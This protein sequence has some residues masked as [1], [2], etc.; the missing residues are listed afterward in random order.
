MR[1]GLKVFLI[2]F[3]L[4]IVAGAVIG[5]DIYLSYRDVQAKLGEFS[6]GT[7]SFVLANN[8]ESVTISTTVTTPKLGYMPKSLRLDITIMKGGSQYGAI[9][10]ITIKLGTSQLI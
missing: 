1:K 6:V 8:N 5:I 7:A 9:Q 10:Q 2:I 3:G 4:I